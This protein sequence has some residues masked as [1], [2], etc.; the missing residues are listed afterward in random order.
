MKYGKI[1]LFWALA[2]PISITMR[3]VQ[4]FGTVEGNTG[5]FKQELAGFGNAITVII[6][7]FAAVG[8]FFGF[9]SHRAPESAPERSPIIAAISICFAAATFYELA[10]IKTAA[11]AGVWQVP[12]LKV[13]SVLAIVFFVVYALSLVSD[14]KIPR[15][16]F[17]IPV[18]YFI[19][20][21][22]CDF[23]SI[24]SLALISDNVLYLASLCSSLVFFLQFFKLYAN[25]DKERNFR[26]LLA[27]GIA[28]SIFCLTQSVS[29]VVYNMMNNVGY[30]HLSAA[31]NYSL[32]ATG[33]FIV[34][35][36]LT[37][38]KRKSRR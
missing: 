24:A 21:I 37:H 18:L 34:I 17:A 32:L 15:G 16:L 19:A 30:S 29:Y 23:T 1:L 36:V 10:T 27:S 3:L 11:F 12:F 22:M 14:I 28:A 7:C 33:L 6:L 4:L 31:A 9:I 25:L 5:F 38:F 26:K 13:L 8:V 35:F 20:K 2:L